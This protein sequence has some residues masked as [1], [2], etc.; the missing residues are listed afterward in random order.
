LLGTSS[1]TDRRSGGAARAR[2]AVLALA[3]AAITTVHLTLSVGT[4]REHVIHVLF[5]GLYLL[6]VIAAAV[7]FRLRGALVSAV[8]V[9]AAYAGHMLLSW[10]HQPMENANQVAMIAVFLLVGA[11][12]GVL[13]EREDRER[14]R[15]LESEQRAQ[16]AAVVQGIAGL[17]S[18]LGFRDE[19]TRAHS[20]HVACLAVEV[21]RG[22]GLS[23]EQLE[24]LRLA[25]LM[26]DVGKIGVR[27][28][29][30]F[31]PQDLTPEER[32]KVE[33]HPALAAEILRPIHGTEEIAE[34][35]LCHHECP[36]GSGYPRGLRGREIPTEARILR[37]A[38]VYSALTEARPYKTGMERERALERMSGMAGTK[39]DARS[40][41]ALRDAVE[42]SALPRTTDG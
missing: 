17:S 19:Y 10:R 33:R 16:R 3:I 34:I 32:V 15:R 26:H 1:K 31:K 29:I 36:D 42:R 24:L 27:D 6:P 35:V 30:L 39:L 2:A 7:W 40:L 5:R 12:S 4:H 41:D 37:V 14:R 11:A 21:G 13:A 18:A 25:G 20:E 23:G 8:V 22:L 28:D 38:D 9:A